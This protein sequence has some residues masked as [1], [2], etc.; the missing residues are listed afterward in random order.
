MQPAA[1]PPFHRL[2]ELSLPSLRHLR[3]AD[4]A[5][6]QGQ[7]D[8]Q[9]PNDRL[10]WP[11]QP[12]LQGDLC[13]PGGALPAVRSVAGAHRVLPPEQHEAKGEAGLG[14]LGPQ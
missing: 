12:H 7:R 14:L 9:V 4:D 2:M 6:L 13:V 10:P 8:V 1:V 5:G 3:E 11:A